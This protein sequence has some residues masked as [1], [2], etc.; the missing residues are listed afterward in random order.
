LLLFF[1]DYS[2]GATGAGS[3]TVP[4]GYTNMLVKCWGSGG[5]GGE[6]YYGPDSRSTGGG[7][8]FVSCLFNNVTSGT[9]YYYVIGEGGD[10]G[11]G[12]F[13]VSPH[14]PNG[15]GI[16]MNYTSGGLPSSADNSIH[17][18]QRAKQLHFLVLLDQ[19]IL[20]FLLLV[21][22]EELLLIRAEKMLIHMEELV[23]VKMVAIQIQRENMVL[24]DTVEMGEPEELEEWE[25]PV[26]TL[27]DPGMT[28][29]YL[30]QEPI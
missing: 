6:N 17:R 30:L 26:M 9:T 16:A 10:V 24:L 27:E 2:S 8:G 19:H 11:Y 28:I 20:L 15:G 18:G 3:F 13:T 1:F 25:E 14:T 5:G 21:E 23:V 7:G 22:A 12:L 4:Y 29:H